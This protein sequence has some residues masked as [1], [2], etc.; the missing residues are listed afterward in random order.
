ML[1]ETGGKNPE[2]LL[3]IQDITTRKR[4]ESSL[5]RAKIQLAAHAVQL[6]ETVTRAPCS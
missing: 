6:E 4:A 3:G 2:V 5:G 1:N